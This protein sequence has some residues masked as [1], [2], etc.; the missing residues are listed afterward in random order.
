MPLRDVLETKECEHWYI[1]STLR[2]WHSGVGQINETSFLGKN[3]SHSKNE[4]KS[5]GRFGTKFLFHSPPCLLTRFRSGCCR[6]KNPIP[7]NDNHQTGVGFDPVY[8]G[9]E[10]VMGWA[11]IAVA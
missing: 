5:G 2:L 8:P 1:A 10:G 7:R 9:A 3:K 11:T 4:A 6:Q